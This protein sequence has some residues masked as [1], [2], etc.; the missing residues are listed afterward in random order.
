MKDGFGRKGIYLDKHLP[1]TSWWLRCDGSGLL[2]LGCLWTQRA[3]H[4]LR[5]LIPFDQIKTPA[6]QNAQRLVTSVMEHAACPSCLPSSVGHYSLPGSP[7]RQHLQQWTS[8]HYS[9]EHETQARARPL[10]TLGD[11]SSGSPCVV[12]SLLC[13]ASTQFASIFIY[14]SVLTNINPNVNKEKC[15]MRCNIRCSRV[16]ERISVKEI[17]VFWPRH[18]TLNCSQWACS[19]LHRGR[20]PISIFMCLWLSKWVAIIKQFGQPSCARSRWVSTVHLPFLQFLLL[21]VDPPYKSHTW[22]YAPIS[23]FLCWSTTILTKTASSC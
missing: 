23:N 14:L 6:T 19:I 11:E 17:H 13:W 7:C 3:L 8:A 20:E 22:H 1:D 5:T 16:G 21:F 12:S 9:V 18:W 10:T 15:S 2:L 4:L